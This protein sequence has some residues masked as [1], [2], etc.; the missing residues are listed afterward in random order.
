MSSWVDLTAFP[1]HIEINCGFH[2]VCSCRLS[3]SVGTHGLMFGMK[4][5]N[6]LE[7][8]CVSCSHSSCTAEK[9]G[10]GA[11]ILQ[12]SEFRYVQAIRWMHILSFELK[13]LSAHESFPK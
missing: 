11:S 6:P 2:T 7:H 10:V 9:F 5:F 12:L 13:A 8:D 1:T 3:Y 4:C